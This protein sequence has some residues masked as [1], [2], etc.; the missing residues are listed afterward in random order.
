MT[1]NGK[2]TFPA[3]KYTEADIKT[4]TFEYVITETGDLAA[5][6]LTKS[7]DINVTV[8]VAVDGTDAGKLNV[9]ATYDNNDTITN[10]YAA[11]GNVTLE[12]TKKFAGAAYD[13]SGK[14]FEF[15]LS[16]NDTSESKKVTEA[17]PK[18][19]FSAIDYTLADAGKTY[20][21]TISE[22]DPGLAGVTASNPIEVKVA[23]VDNGDGTL[24]AT[25]TYTNGNEI[26][27]TYATK[28]T[29]AT[30]HVEKKI[31]DQSNSNANG[32]F[33]FTL[34]DGKGYSD[35][36]SIDTS[37]TSGVD[38]DV[39]T[40]TEAGVYEYTLQEVAG[41]AEGFSY[42][43]TEY[44]V[45]VTVTDDPETAQLS[46]TVAYGEAKDLTITNT[47]KATATSIKFEVT[48]TL[49]GM[50]EGID[51]VDFNFTLSGAAGEIETITIHGAG[52]KE[53]KEI[54]Y[55]KAGTYEYTVVEKN[56]GAGGYSYDNATYTI[57]VEVKDEGGVLKA[58]PTITKNGESAS[59]ITFENN[60]SAKGNITLQVNK[61]L[62]GR[63]W[64]EGETH[65]FILKDSEGKQV[66]E[67][68]AVT[69]EGVISFDE[70]EYTKAGTYT[71]KVEEA[72]GEGYQDGSLK[73]ADPITVTVTVA[74]DGK[75]NLTATPSYGDTAPTAT[76][77]YTA[78]GS[79]TINVTKNL[80]GRDWLE[81]ESFTFAL[82]DSEGNQ[83]G[84]AKTVTKDSAT[85]A[86]K[87]EYTQADTE[88]SEDGTAE[89]TYTVKEIGEMPANIAQPDDL[90]V[91]V[92]LKDNGHGTIEATADQ[93]DGYTITNEYVPTPT[94]AQFHVEKEIDDRSNSGANGEFTFVLKDADGNELESKTIN[95]NK[96][97]GTD[98]TSIQYTKAGTY[99]YT[100]TEQKGDVTGY[101]YDETE[102]AVV[103]SVVDDNAGTLTATITYDGKDGLV[104]TNVYEAK[105]VD[106]IVDV[107]KTIYGIE[108]V[109]SDK[110][111]TF[112][113]ELTGDNVDG[114]KT[115]TIS[116]EGNASFDAITFTQ[117][118]T[119]TLTVHEVEGSAPG[120]IYDDNDVTVTVVVTDNNGQLEAEVSY[121]KG[122]AEGLETAIFT[123]GYETT[124]IT[125]Y[126]VVVEKMLE[127]RKL[128]EGEFEF[129]LVDTNGEVV[130]TGTNDANGRVAFSGIDF[131]EAGEYYFLVREIVDESRGEI[132]F[133]TNEYE[134]TIVVKDN[135][136]GEL[137][138]E[139]DTSSEVI[140]KNKY[141][142][143][144]K[145]ENPQTS[146][147]ILSV[148]AT[149]VIST[150]G[151]IGAMFFGFRSKEENE[152]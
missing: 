71:Y 90:T 108:N 74:D 95:T 113:F 43:T 61:V 54:S 56:G 50:N 107:E 1:Q 77:T 132:D 57:K 63:N 152:A 138:V 133:D 109:D 129:E 45:T 126:E 122:A 51:P 24:S 97:T 112:E 20:T 76:N 59:K 94:N 41:N 18:A 80:E 53:F 34:S 131:E 10:T 26:T 13:W 101:T 145:G 25:P 119:Y 104:I 27:N 87:V 3:L 127:G 64:L 44:K 143:P 2:V 62:D 88:E 46:A 123:N 38:F 35:T 60:Y 67:A 125:D 106:V 92:S 89:I 140:F 86:F 69:A 23:V 17:E 148:V 83:I 130:A 6:G 135:G 52:K 73:P 124:P 121:G 32:V 146:D 115:I 16:G 15:V 142:E 75:G 117:V 5:N 4:G 116:G 65:T 118:G 49:N 12:A 102:H 9:T 96:E 47:Y 149:L 40:Y 139:S 128:N 8:T 114:K 39:I 29:T 33:E 21:Y 72:L 19:T 31:D 111:P 105:P 151:L 78:T 91:T 99:N 37:K 22:T 79:V 147:D 28:S 36:K 98:F 58:T 30:L 81:G 82:Y 68:K 141:N 70:I 84:D 120:Y 150:I 66:G 110:L 144:G 55:D 11:T 100:I 48:K 14:E 136:E 103:V 7:A 93:E 134:V 85:A 42:D 137:V